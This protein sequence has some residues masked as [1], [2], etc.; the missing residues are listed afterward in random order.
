MAGDSFLRCDKKDVFSNK[1]KKLCDSILKIVIHKRT[2]ISYASFAH[3]NDNRVATCLLS[4]VFLVC[5][6][7][8]QAYFYNIVIVGKIIV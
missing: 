1:I 5:L 4:C 6:L 7:I 3:L 2:I 8:T